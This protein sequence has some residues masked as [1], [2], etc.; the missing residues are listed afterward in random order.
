MNMTDSKKFIKLVFVVM[1]LC[2]VMVLPI[3]LS[4]CNGGGNNFSGE[5][6]SVT[7]LYG[8][9][10]TVPKTVNKII[11]LGS[12]TLRMITYAGAQDKVVGVENIE[13]ASKTQ[14]NSIIGKPYTYANKDLFD[15]LPSVGQ[16]GGKNKTP[17]KEKIL[18]LMPDV[19]FCSYDKGNFDKLKQDLN[20]L[21]PIIYV[22]FDTNIIN[23][24]TQSNIEKCFDII[25]KVMN[26]ETRC[27]EVVKKIKSVFSDL[28]DKTKNIPEAEKPV[29][30]VGG[31]S[32]S[33]AHEL[34]YTYANYTVLT[35]INTK[36]V[37]DMAEGNTAFKQEGS[38]KIDLEFV[39]N[40]NPKYIFVDKANL[41]L[42]NQEYNNKK[43]ALDN[44]DAIQNGNVFGTIS[45]NLYS[46]NIELALATSYY[47][48]K[49]LYPTQFNDVNIDT[50]TDELLEFFVGKKIYE[51]MKDNN[52]FFSKVTL[53]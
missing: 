53:G 37:A 28:N 15:S 14:F 20:N 12:G 1:L 38:Y 19:I 13:K 10:V 49:I 27:N 52:M 39:I 33:G 47:L 25:G 41:N 36:S 35:A 48:G 24:T 18:Q 23:A 22:S 45:Y 50:K 42:V 4:A 16:G 26:K 5:T 3:I 2:T 51:V 7:D 8:N 32:Y 43:A 17:D 46:T 40:K 9:Q 34:S 21:I 30:Y 44:V 31:I 29:S 11:C 6:Q